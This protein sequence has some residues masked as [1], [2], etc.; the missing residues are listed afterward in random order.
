M[1]YG[2]RHLL[3]YPRYNF[4]SAARADQLMFPDPYYHYAR[5]S[6]VFIDPTVALPISN[7][8][9]PPKCGMRLRK[10]SAASTTMPK[11]PINKH[12]QFQT[13]KEKIGLPFDRS[14]IDAP[15]F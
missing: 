10:M 6:Q 15:R 12:S 5:N 1:S 13:G 7:Q 8:L 11:A 14:V 3:S 2:S 9:G 4:G